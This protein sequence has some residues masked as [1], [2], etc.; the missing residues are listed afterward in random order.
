[1][2]DGGDLG[3]NF[4]SMLSGLQSYVKVVK[5]YIEDLKGSGTG[6]TVKLGTMFRLQFA[7]QVLT[8][9]LEATSN[10]LTAANTEMI[11][12]AKAVKGQ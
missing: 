9:Y 12:M 7:M 8:Q 5:G 10:T 6:G 3:F 2:A 1:M 11:N 4:K